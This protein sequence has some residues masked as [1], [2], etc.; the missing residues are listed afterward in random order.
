MPERQAHCP[1][2]DTEIDHLDY[3]SNIQ[4]WGTCDLD[5]DDF[6]NRGSDINETEYTCP[7]CEH[8]I[9]LY[10]DNFYENENEEKPIHNNNEPNDIIDNEPNSYGLKFIICPN[11]SEKTEIEHS[12]EEIECP[13][14]KTIINRNNAKII[15][16]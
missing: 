2:C 4:E 8:N 11:C 9:D 14:C 16:I 7:E 15:N 6:N 12:S 5:G 1:H 13:K 10:N 3:N